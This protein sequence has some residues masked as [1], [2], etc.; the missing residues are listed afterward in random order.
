M[1]CMKN[2]RGVHSDTSKV[3]LPTQGLQG[4]M[5]VADFSWVFRII[6]PSFSAAIGI[7]AS[8]ICGCLLTTE[9]VCVH[10]HFCVCVSVSVS[11]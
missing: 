6:F 11:M 7:C 4:K 5:V 1:R 8:V 2:K 3:K 10:V 9:H